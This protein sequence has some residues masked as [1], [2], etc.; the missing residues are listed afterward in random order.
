MP[1]KPPRR[2]LLSPELATDLSE[3][4][5]REK[6]SE[7]AGD[8]EEVRWLRRATKRLE[9]ENKQLR[10]ELGDLNRRFLDVVRGKL[11]ANEFLTRQLPKLLL[12]SRLLNDARKGSCFQP[13]GKKG[14]IDALGRLIEQV[15]GEIGTDAPAKEVWRGLYKLWEQG[16]APA[17]QEITDIDSTPLDDLIIYW[18]ASAG[19]EKSITWASFPGRLARHKK[20]ARR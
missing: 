15:W 16:N 12:Q 20:N 17:I 11:S 8:T 3:R 7:A 4:L 5:A 13:G 10:G 1:E 18:K 14:R 6:A 19:R 9:K 2:G